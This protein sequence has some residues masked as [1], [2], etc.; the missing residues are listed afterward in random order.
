MSSVEAVPKPVVR[1]R[2]SS[3]SVSLRRAGTLACAA[4]AAAAACPTRLLSPPAPLVRRRCTST[5]S[6]LAKVR[7][8]TRRTRCW[9]R[10][11]SPLLR[12]FSSALATS[13]A[14][15]RP[16]G[17]ACTSSC[18]H[19]VATSQLRLPRRQPSLLRGCSLVGHLRARALRLA[20]GCSRACR[21]RPPPL[22]R[23]PVRCAGLAQAR[24][25]LWR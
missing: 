11:A 24:P 21:R 5:S 6:V 23:P 18:T 20:P 22:W 17:R 2:S 9:T 7:P 14:G 4:G 12:C 19:L 13:S 25:H 3:R 15:G 1:Y 8:R 10:R 16:R